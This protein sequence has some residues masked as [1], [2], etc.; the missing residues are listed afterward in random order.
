LSLK[1]SHSFLKK[2]FIKCYTSIW[3]S[4]PNKLSL[5]TFLLVSLKGS[6][7]DPALEGNIGKWM[8]SGPKFKADFHYEF[9]LKKR[10]P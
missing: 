9:S 3:D 2:R 4:F 5:K 7:T 8:K 6:P 1:K 10:D